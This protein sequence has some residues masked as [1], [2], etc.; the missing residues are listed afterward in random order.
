MI[1]DRILFPAVRIF[2]SANINFSTN[3]MRRLFA[4]KTIRTLHLIAIRVGAENVQR[5]MAG[6]VQRVFC[7]FNL[8]YDLQTVSDNVE[9]QETSEKNLQK[10]VIA[11]NAPKQVYII[12][13]LINYILKND[14]CL[15]NFN[16]YC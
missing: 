6:T 9:T 13:N 2:S 1:V 12:H 3:R 5:H 7:T 14:L 11:Q 4:C 10:V 8:I 15:V 16:I